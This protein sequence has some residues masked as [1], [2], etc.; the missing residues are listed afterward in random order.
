ML[1]RSGEAVYD[2]ADVVENVYAEPQ[3]RPNQDYS[4]AETGLCRLV[5]VE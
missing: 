3:S 5:A 4:Y 2:S 1:I